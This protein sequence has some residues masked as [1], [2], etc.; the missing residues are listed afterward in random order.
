MNMSIH[1]VKEVR[2]AAPKNN[3]TAHGAKFA[4]RDLIVIDE[5]GHKYEITLFARNASALKAVKA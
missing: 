2:F 3:E 4:C 1:N 5:N